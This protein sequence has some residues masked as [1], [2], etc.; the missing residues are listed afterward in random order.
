M[1]WLIVISVIFHCFPSLLSW[2]SGYSR[3]TVITVG[4]KKIGILSKRTRVGIACFHLHKRRKIKPIISIN[5][6]RLQ[7][8]RP[9]IKPVCQLAP[10]SRIYL[11]NLK[12]RGKRVPTVPLETKSG[13]LFRVVISSW[14]RSFSRD[15]SMETWRTDG[16]RVSRDGLLTLLLHLS[17][18]IRDDTMVW[19]PRD[20]VASWGWEHCWHRR[21][22]LTVFSGWTHWPYVT[23][24]PCFQKSCLHYH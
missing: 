20:H 6:A 11:G 18:D 10:S 14:H 9:N 7:V 17:R 8:S 4:L 13:V 5:L 22:C 12:Q 1:F 15:V 23:K 19:L 2:N 21:L 3:G 24:A 16:S